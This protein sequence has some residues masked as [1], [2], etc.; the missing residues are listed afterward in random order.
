MAE[1]PEFLSKEDNRMSILKGLAG[2]GLIASGAVLTFFG[3]ETWRHKKDDND[4][5]EF[6]DEEFEESNEEGNNENKEG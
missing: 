3:G 1:M 4:V 2:L 5:D 6:D